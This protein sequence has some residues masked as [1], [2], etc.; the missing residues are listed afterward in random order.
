MFGSDQNGI[1][2]TVEFFFLNHPELMKPP[3]NLCVE[4]MG[5]KKEKK[6]LKTKLWKEKIHPELVKHKK[7]LCI[8][9]MGRREKKKKKKPTEISILLLG[10]KK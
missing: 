3:R 5:R 4:I 2:I 10:F 8:E 1:K 7:N 9:I 6:S